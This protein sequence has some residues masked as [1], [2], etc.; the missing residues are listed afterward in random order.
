MIDIVPISVQELETHLRQKSATSEKLPGK[1]RSRIID[2]S[3]PLFFSSSVANA[4]LGLSAEIRASELLNLFRGQTPDGKVALL[5]ESSSKSEPAGWMIRATSPESLAVLWGLAPRSAKSEM[6]S[7][8]ET[9]TGN[10]LDAIEQFV[11]EGE[12]NRS[13]DRGI[14][15]AMVP[16][17][18]FLNSTPQLRTEVFLPNL[19]VTV[20]GPCTRLARAPE[21]LKPVGHWSAYHDNRV[22]ELLKHRLGLEFHRELGKPP[23]IIGLSP[24]LSQPLTTPE[25]KGTTDNISEKLGAKKFAAAAKEYGWG[26]SNAADLLELARDQRADF[27]RLEKWKERRAQETK[28]RKENEAK[29]KPGIKNLWQ[30]N[31]LTHSY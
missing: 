18:T 29:Q 11:A 10:C 16:S 9:S 1:W 6:L 21:F 14:L 24:K 2:S 13:N 12:K 28:R 20:G 31:T 15:F 26:K 3:K 17:P 22:C 30:K 4:T 27:K 7:C 5:S 23:E 25:N 8:H 19:M